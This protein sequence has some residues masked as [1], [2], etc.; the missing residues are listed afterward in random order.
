MYL[1]PGNRTGH[2]WEDQEIGGTEED[3]NWELESVKGHY[4]FHKNRERRSMQLEKN[5][6]DL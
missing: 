4:K 1:V 5:P 2:G 3:G 6:D